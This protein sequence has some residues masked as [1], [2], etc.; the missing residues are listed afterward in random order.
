MTRSSTYLHSLLQQLPLYLWVTDYYD[1]TIVEKFKK[2]ITL[3][4]MKE[5]SKL[6]GMIVLQR[7]S[8]LSVM[9]VEKNHFLHILK[10]AGS[11]VSLG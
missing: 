10:I 6:S 8:R 5:D 4:E 9:P 11:K 3:D 2:V 1:A 7:G